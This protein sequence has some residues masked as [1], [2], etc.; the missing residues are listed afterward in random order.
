MESLAIVEKQIKGKK[1]FWGEEIGYLDLV[2][3]WLAHWL[4]VMEEV[5]GM[6]L[7]NKETF[8]S[9]HQWCLNFIHTPIITKSIPSRENLLEYLKGSLR[10]YLSL[11]A[12][13]K[14]K[15]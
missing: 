6:K 12:A 8:P 5:G 7:L 4:N 13:N 9:L 11:A 10:Y 3:G 15:Q 14:V 1:F 2:Y